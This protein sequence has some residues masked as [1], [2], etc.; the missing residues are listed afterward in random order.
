MRDHRATWFI[1]FFLP[2]LIS[3]L[4]LFLIFFKIFLPTMQSIILEKQKSHVKQMVQ[5]ALSILENYE[6]M[7]QSGEY[8]REEAKEM[9]A[10]VIGNIRYGEN[11]D[12]YFWITT[13]RPDMIY[14]PYQKNL[15]GM[16][17][18]EYEDP[19]GKRLFNE[20]ASIAEADGQGF[21][22]Y[23]WQKRELSTDFFEKIS[24]VALFKPWNWIIG[25]GIYLDEFEIANEAIKNKMLYITTIILFILILLL[26][27]T[28][29]KT[30]RQEDEKFAIQSE[31]RKINF[32]YRGIFD[33]TFQFMGILDPSGTVLQV[34]RKS[35]ALIGKNENDV[36]GKKFW[37]TPWWTHSAEEMDKVKT[38]ILKADRGETVRFETFHNNTEGNRIY[39]DFTLSPILDYNGKTINM[40]PE[41]RDITK[42]KNIEKKLKDANLE[43]EKQVKE[44]SGKLEEFLVN[45]EGTQQQL[46][47][48]EKMAALG[49]LV[50]G[51]AHEI[52]TP[53][54]ISV[55]A[56]SYLDDRTRRIQKMLQED[57]LTEEEFNN[58][59]ETTVESSA[60]ILTNLERAASQIKVFKQV[61]VDQS[62]EGIRRFIL[63]SYIQ[64][65]IKSLHPELKKKPC[66]IDVNCPEELEI[67]TYPGTIS[68]IISNLIMNSIKHGFKNRD[69]GTISIDCKRKGNH[70]LMNYSDNGQGINEESAGKLFEP[71]YTTARGEGG[72]GL[73]LHIVY[74]LV[75]QKLK[76][77]ITINTQMESGLGFLIDFPIE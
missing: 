28:S 17:V 2:I 12:E 68:Q 74:N 54:G 11:N 49:R 30:L 65:V 22:R 58:Y 3:I 55:T 23:M 10:E 66:L 67:T 35:L 60:M 73:G 25:T 77:N 32:L 63:K 71:F 75:N 21:V 15:N 45:L 62:D 46:I 24:Y 41:G 48:S 26:G 13:T 39:V 47:Q 44:R 40:L 29:V 16:Y 9:A 34:N 56:A 52:N 6:K 37:D 61:A 14:H 42:R 4:L 43:L 8:T 36:I 5:S 69:S 64:E 50:A 38:A 20:M 57:N 19:S 31:L 59:L 1:H 18:G 33:N 27:F 51:V 7:I 76:G 53:L 70:I 72:T